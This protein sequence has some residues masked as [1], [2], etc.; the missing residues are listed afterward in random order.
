ML[1]HFIGQK[2][3]SKLC[4]YMDD[5]NVYNEKYDTLISKLEELYKPRVI[6][7]A[8]CYKFHCRKQDQNESVQDY[9]N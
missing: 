4:D 5:A 3:F 6:E 8:E 1:L 9:F 2:V 7:I